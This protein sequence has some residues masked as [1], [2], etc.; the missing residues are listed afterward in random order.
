MNLNSRNWLK[1]ALCCLLCARLGHAASPPPERPK[2]PNQQQTAQ[3]G[4][5][6]GETKCDHVGIRALEPDFFQTGTVGPVVACVPAL[7]CKDD[8]RHHPVLDKFCQDVFGSK[9]SAGKCDGEEKCAAFF[10]AKESKKVTLDWKDSRPG[11]KCPRDKKGHEG[12]VEC[13]AKVDLGKG[14]KLQC[15]CA[16]P[17]MA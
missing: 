10:D 9:C 14:G 15:K 8:E 2:A 4:H 5:E 6:V 12:D 16:C 11:D 13:T 1:L 3:Q 17:G 7:D